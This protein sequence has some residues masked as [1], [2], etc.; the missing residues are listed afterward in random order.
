MNTYAKGQRNEKK[1]MDYFKENGYIVI[2]AKITRHGKNDFFGLFDLC[3]VKQGSPT[4]WVQ[5]K[6]NTCSK[7]VRAQ[8]QEF[9]QK[10]FLPLVNI[11]LVMVWV[12]RKGWKYHTWGT[13]GEFEK[14]E[15]V[16]RCDAN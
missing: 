4:V 12:D 15:P 7:K 10:N 3:A 5:V 13:S 9:A 14:I 1:A 16:F 2:K 8:I 6:S 11:P